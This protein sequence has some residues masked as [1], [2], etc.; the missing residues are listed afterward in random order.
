LPLADSKE[1][2]EY[3][4]KRQPPPPPP[5]Q[6]AMPRFNTA[7]QRYKNSEFTQTA[8]KGILSFLNELFFGS[9]ET[10]VKKKTNI[11]RKPDVTNPD[12][13]A[14]GVGDFGDEKKKRKGR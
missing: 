1:N 11:K 8:R 5:R 10:R 9:T 6:A 2:E 3:W 4:R 7:L 13:L 14:W 12:Y